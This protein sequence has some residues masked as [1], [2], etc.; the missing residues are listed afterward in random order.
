M[1]C[2]ENTIP[3]DITP[4][5]TQTSQHGH[6]PPFPSQNFTPTHTSSHHHHH[7]PSSLQTSFHRDIS[8]FP[9]QNLN[10]S[11]TSFSPCIS[12]PH[13]I[14]MS[15]QSTARPDQLWSRHLMFIAIIHRKPT[16]YSTHSFRTSCPPHPTL[17]HYYPSLPHPYPFYTPPEVANFDPLYL[18][19][20]ASYVETDSANQLVS[21]RSIDFVRLVKLTRA[22]AFLVFFLRVPVRRGGLGVLPQR[23]KLR[24]VCVESALFLLFFLPF[25]WWG[26]G[27]DPPFLGLGSM[28]RG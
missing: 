11:N 16:F 24:I 26:G 20:E 9:S 5:L 23:E 1:N 18:R 17:P 7:H 28:D 15:K 14:P 25:P 6:I 27:G 10:F 19:G 2:R 12:L 3:H 8:P 13:S 4:I 21:L 22:L